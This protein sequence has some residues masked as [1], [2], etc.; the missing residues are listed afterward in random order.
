MTSGRVAKW[1]KKEGDKIASGDVLVSDSSENDT[2][3]LSQCACSV[4]LHI[5]PLFCL[6]PPQGEIET[7]KASG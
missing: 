1:N 2:L 3:S 7:D 5:S 6:S 4:L